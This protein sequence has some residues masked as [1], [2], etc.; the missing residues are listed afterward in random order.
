[1]IWHRVTRECL[2]HLGGDMRADLGNRTEGLQPSQWGLLKERREITEI[3]RWK[4]ADGVETPQ[5]SQHPEVDRPEV[6]QRMKGL[7]AHE[8]LKTF[9]KLFCYYILLLF[10]NMLRNQWEVLVETWHNC[11][12]FLKKNYRF[13]VDFTSSIWILFIS[14]FLHIHPP[15]LKSPFPPPNQINLKAK[16]NK[17][18]AQNRPNKQK[19]HCGSCSV[20]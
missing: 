13:F 10:W 9:K 3:L 15:S 4:H 2:I 14:L 8:V 16:T 5:R 7:R 20:I 1:M 18:K 19:S 12:R 6:P 17:Q 11:T